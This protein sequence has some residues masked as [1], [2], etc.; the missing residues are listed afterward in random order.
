MY[1][2]DQSLENSENDSN[3]TEDSNDENYY[4]NDYPIS[5]SNSSEQSQT[6]QSSERSVEDVYTEPLEV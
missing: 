5:N 2:I 3:Y 1:F 6:E 4:A